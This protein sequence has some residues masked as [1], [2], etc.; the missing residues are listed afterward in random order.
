M[1]YLKKGNKQFVKNYCPVSLL[2]ICSKIFERIIYT[3]T[4]NYLIDNSL[5]SQNESGFKHGDSSLTN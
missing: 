1:V 4:Y 5:I 3:N 2:P